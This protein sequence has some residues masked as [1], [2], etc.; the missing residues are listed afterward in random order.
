MATPLPTG[1]RVT[2]SHIDRVSAGSV[3]AG[4]VGRPVAVRHLA[5]LREGR[6]GGSQARHGRPVDALAGQAGLDDVRQALG[7][8]HRTGEVGVRDVEARH[9]RLVKAQ[10]RGVL[11]EHPGAAVD[12]HVHGQQLERPVAHEVEG[13]L[14]RVEALVDGDRG[15]AA[16]LRSKKPGRSSAMTFSQWGQVGEKKKTPRTIGPEARTGRP[17][18]T[19]SRRGRRCRGLGCGGGR[20]GGRRGV[21]GQRRGRRHRGRR[22]G[23]DRGGRRR[24]IGS[25]GCRGG[26]AD[27]QQEGQEHEGDG[28]ETHA[29]RRVSRTVGPR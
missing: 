5:R 13:H 2:R 29:G 15:L 19:R 27:S 6:Q 1:S 23:C 21:R 8:V 24:R 9:A 14:T 20:S 25:L 7:D 28:T 10:A 3:T 17:T 26:G 18:A 16:R 22:L 12:G 4:I 11:A